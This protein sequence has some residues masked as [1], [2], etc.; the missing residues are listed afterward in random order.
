MKILKR[1]AVLALGVLIALS[2]LIALERLLVGEVRAEASTQYE[3]YF[4][5]PES[6]TLIRLRT[7]PG[8]DGQCYISH[9]ELLTVDYDEYG[10][11]LAEQFVRFQ[12]KM[13]QEPYELAATIDALNTEVTKPL[14]E[15]GIS[16]TVV[17][18]NGCKNDK[19]KG[20]AI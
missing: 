20:V 12:L 16:S 19:P 4:V 3:N 5:V 7:A 10:D 13:V 15:L 8:G 1:V 9:W 2:I 18:L 6:D 11:T 14:K 17:F